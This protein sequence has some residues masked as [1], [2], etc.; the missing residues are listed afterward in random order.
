M[1][2]SAN[3]KIAMTEVNRTLNRSLR[4]VNGSDI[5]NKSLE[6]S[7]LMRQRNNKE[8]VK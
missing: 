3:G 1:K 2:H 8:M 6:E 7:I 4:V 5:L